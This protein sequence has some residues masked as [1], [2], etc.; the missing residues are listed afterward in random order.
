MA[1]LD[2]RTERELKAL[3]KRDGLKKVIVEILKLSEK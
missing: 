1:Y 3:L 2:I